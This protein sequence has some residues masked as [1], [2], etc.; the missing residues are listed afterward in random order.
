M[1]KM[2]VSFHVL[3]CHLYIF[4]GEASNSY[5][6]FSWV[7][8]VIFKFQVQCKESLKLMIYLKHLKTFQFNCEFLVLFVLE[9]RSDKAELE[10]GG[11]PAPVSS[12]A[13]LASVVMEFETP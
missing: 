6:V 10:Q 9:R 11:T 13:S 1:V 5:F 4:F 3:L 12:C 2:L 7:V 8:R